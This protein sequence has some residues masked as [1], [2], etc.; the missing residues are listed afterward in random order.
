MTAVRLC[1]FSSPKHRTHTHLST[2]GKLRDLEIYGAPPAG[3]MM[4]RRRASQNCLTP[5]GKLTAA[6]LRGLHMTTCLN[7]ITNAS[8]NSTIHMGHPR[9]TQRRQY[10]YLFTYKYHQPVGQWHLSNPLHKQYV[11]TITIGLLGGSTSYT[12]VRRTQASHF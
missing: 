11:M 4:A 8:E 10:H 12:R 6:R 7:R 1:Y 3:F 2:H 5:A 9:L